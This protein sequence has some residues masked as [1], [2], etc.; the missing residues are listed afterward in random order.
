MFLFPSLASIFRQ[1]EKEVLMQLQTSLREQ[2]QQRMLDQKK[3][4][5][6]REDQLVKQ[7]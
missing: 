5:L 1:E 2:R 3:R 7:E 6:E 4:G